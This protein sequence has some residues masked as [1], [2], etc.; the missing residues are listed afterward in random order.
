MPPAESEA[1]EV[2]HGHYVT[3]MADIFMRNGGLFPVFI[4]YN[5]SE[6]DLYPLLN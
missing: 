4:P 2:G 3:E 5:V 6:A 1:L